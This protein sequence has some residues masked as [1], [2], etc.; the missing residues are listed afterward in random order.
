MVLD[1]QQSLLD[2]IVAKLVVDQLLDDEVHSLLEANLIAQLADDL[3]VVLREQALE[4][5]LDVSLLADSD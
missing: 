1:R 3:L 5:A 4:D 2:H